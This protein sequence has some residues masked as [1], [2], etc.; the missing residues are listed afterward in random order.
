MVTG[1]PHSLGRWPLRHLAALPVRRLPPVAG[2]LLLGLA[3]A[4]VLA[5]RSQVSGDQLNML[6]RG[7]L[8]TQGKWVHIG[9]TTSANGKAPGGSLSLLAG[10]PLLLWRDYRAVALLVV[11]AHLGGFLLLD[12][13]LREAL[14][15]AGR[16][17]FAVAYW[18]GPWRLLY[19]AFVWNANLMPFFGA[20]H[21]ASS[22]ALRRRAG[23]WATLAHV[24]ALG[25]GL[26]IH[27][28]AA[29]LG[30]L[31][32]LLLS[33]RTIR[34][35]WGAAALGATLVG[36]SLIPWVEEV[37]ANAQLLP[38][39]KG[40][41]FRGLLLIFPLLR[42]LLL[43][44]RFPSLMITSRMHAYDFTAA[45]GHTA[46]ALLTPLALAV[47]W[48]LGLASLAIPI[49]AAPWFFKKIKRFRWVRG[50]QNGRE[51]LRRYVVVTF[52]AAAL[53]FAASPTT[54]MMWQ[55]FAILPTVVLGL[56]LW[57]EAVGR[58][59]WR[60][61]LAPVACLWL[62][63]AL[64]LSLAAA[65]GSPMYRRGGRSATTAVLARP[66]PMLEELNIVQHSS[67]HVAPEGRFTPDVFL[68]NPADGR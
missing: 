46:D 3:L 55:G 31:T 16:R 66:H 67:V 12:R 36:I 42:G 25:I 1:L 51:W 33:T 38:A 29:L 21:L 9:M 32:F 61:L 54:P 7:W 43:W 68:P 27:A 59:R 30:L 28:S 22:W 20:I 62:A 19:S 17:L 41:P 35:H 11:M 45:F 8:F 18:L 23:F 60:S 57:A 37:I 10:V 44:L 2:L 26:Q 48:L 6:A 64:T 34:L 52:F 5:L 4:V 63:G 13:M 65:A 56:V 39:G 50:G 14:S 47:A 53:S 24:L 58:T 15:E 49:L 40:F